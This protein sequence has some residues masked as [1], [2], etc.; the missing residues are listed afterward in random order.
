MEHIHRDHVPLASLSSLLTSGDLH[1]L[2][3]S[4]KTPNQGLV[5]FYP[6]SPDSDVRR[7][8]L[9][10]HVHLLTVQGHPEFTPSIVT[11]LTGEMLADGVVDMTILEDN[12]KYNQAARIAA[13]NGA[14]QIP[15]GTRILGNVF[16]ET[17]G[18]R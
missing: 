10:E 2:G 14:T 5:K 8:I 12:R 11:S 6:Y 4:S 18:V 17:L 13:F 16:W 15:N 7:S 1:I 9:P 3:C